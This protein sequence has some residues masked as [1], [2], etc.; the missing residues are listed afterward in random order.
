MIGYRNGIVSFAVYFQPKGGVE[1][2]PH[3]M[4]E[5]GIIKQLEK[6][7]KTSVSLPLAIQS[8]IHFEKCTDRR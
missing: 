3:R 1:E 5:A 7:G 6:L 2:G 8:L 4:R